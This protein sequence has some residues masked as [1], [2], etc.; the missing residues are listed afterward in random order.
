MVKHCK[1]NPQKTEN[2]FCDYCGKARNECCCENL[3][4]K[5]YDEDSTEEKN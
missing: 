1:C 3:E 2:E 4:V 5:I